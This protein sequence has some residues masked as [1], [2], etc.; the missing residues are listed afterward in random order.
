MRI[1]VKIEIA[2]SGTV[3]AILGSKAT[4]ALVADRFIPQLSLFDLGGKPDGLANPAS[5]WP[6]SSRRV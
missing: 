4:G 6:D 3:S 2:R 1:P 5:C